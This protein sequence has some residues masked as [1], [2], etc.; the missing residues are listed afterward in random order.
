MAITK[1]TLTNKNIVA[2]IRVLI[3]L[4]NL[5]EI[6]TTPP[7]ASKYDIKPDI[8]GAA[9]CIHGYATLLGFGITRIRN[10]IVETIPIEINN[11]LGGR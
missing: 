2:G 4:L 5:R 11:N 6:A 10:H 3:F 1:T 9:T 7:T 8:N